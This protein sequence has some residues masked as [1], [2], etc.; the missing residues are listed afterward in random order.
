[1]PAALHVTT[2][3]HNV[4]TRAG[5]VAAAA[6]AAA[7]RT[8]FGMFSYRVPHVLAEGHV[9]VEQAADEGGP[10]LLI[11]HHR[12]LD[13]VADRDVR[14]VPDATVGEA[15]TVLVVRTNAH[16]D[17]REYLSLAGVGKA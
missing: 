10:R 2:S 17:D 14:H 16:I 3:G 9:G 15:D 12:P 6:A 1:M 11:D 8:T 4:A 7:G 13:E 5:A